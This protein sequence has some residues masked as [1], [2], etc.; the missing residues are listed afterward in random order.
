MSNNSIIASAAP[1]FSAK[2]KIGLHPIFKIIWIAKYT[3][4]STFFSSVFCN[5]YKIKAIKIVVYN[6]IH[7]GVK[8]QFGSE[9]GG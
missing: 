5:T 4:P 1:M 6:T 2:K 8:T 9:N 7:A 3:Y